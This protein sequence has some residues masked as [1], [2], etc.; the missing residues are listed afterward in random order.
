MSGARAACSRA[1]RRG[2]HGG[3]SLPARVAGGMRPQKRGGG[4]FFIQPRMQRAPPR[5]GAR[6]RGGDVWLKVDP[7][8]RTLLDCRETLRYRAGNGGAGS[9]N[10]RT[11]KNGEDVIVWLPPGTVVRDAD[12]GELLGDFTGPGIERLVAKGGRGGAG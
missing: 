11:G 2:E 7:H 6:G 12:T 9:G 3:P 1:S 10:N 4:G 8:V 5:G